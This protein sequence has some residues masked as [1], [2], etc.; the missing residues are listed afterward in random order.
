MG[1][2]SAIDVLS[3]NK[4]T[5]KKISTENCQFLPLLKSLY[6]AYV[7]AMDKKLYSDDK[8]AIETIGSF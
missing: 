4:K 5:I 3:K 2:R 1:T 6:I 7:C 8:T